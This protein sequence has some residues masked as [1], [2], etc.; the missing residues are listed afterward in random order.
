[1]PGGPGELAF[2]ETA[3]GKRWMKTLVRR[4]G[5]KDKAEALQKRFNEMVLHE[6]TEIVR[7][8]IR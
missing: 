1:M 8:R 7:R 4:E 5:G 2:T 6:K 3:L